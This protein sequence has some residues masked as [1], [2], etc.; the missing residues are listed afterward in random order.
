MTD[1]MTKE[2]NKFVD[3][4][5]NNRHNLHYISLYFELSSVPSFMLHSRGKYKYIY[6][7]Y[8]YKLMLTTMLKL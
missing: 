4:V 1:K 6:W 2:L 8:V 3:I 7:Y 5:C